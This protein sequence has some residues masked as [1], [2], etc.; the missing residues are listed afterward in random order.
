[1]RILLLSLYFEPDIG[2]NAVIVSE[3]AHELD[4]LGHQ[5]T[6][7]TSFP[8]YKGNVLEDSYRGK[9][10][11][12]KQRENIHVIRTY[13]YTSPEKDRFLVRLLNYVSFNIL[14]TLAG[15]FS[16]KQ[17]LILAPSPPLSIGLSAAIIGFFKRIPYVYN[18]QDINPDVLIKL[19][20]LKN[21]LFI[22]FSKWLE[23]FVYQHARHIT[24][25]S[26]GFKRNLLKKGVPVKKIS[27]VP[28]FV[29]PDFI[30][31][32]PRQN[33]FRKRFELEGKFIIL[34]AGNLGHSQDLVQI[35]KI[36]KLKQGDDKLAFV[37]VG[38]GSRK[39]FLKE[40]AKTL[41][42]NNVHFIPFQPW[43]DVPLIYAAADVSLVT[44]K[45]DIALD[46]VPSKIY[47][48]M[49]SK[50]P[51]LAAVD[52]GSDA[53]KLIREAKCGI[54]VEP[55]NDRALLDAISILRQSPE[56]RNE[57]GKKG[58][59]FVLKRYTRR[60]VGKKYHQLINGLRYGK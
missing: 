50:R 1:M 30:K 10:I 46:S 4:R 37:I 12:K 52:Q 43:E 54:C 35:L 39:S 14:S 40:K 17:D 25:L 60:V 58:R 57:M 5:I 18:V 6:V 53:W 41:H 22:R 23:K 26:E 36:A 47:T 45:E 2:A 42:L 3:L 13:I 21:P 7:I 8:H 28:N 29:D 27:I 44:L 59:N 32:L 56:L 20:I 16:G 34:Y 38:G 9:L 24:V 33:S 15:I 31:P 49:A 48:I 51:V 19:G 11:V 55:D